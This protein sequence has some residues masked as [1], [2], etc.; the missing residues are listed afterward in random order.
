MVK[1]KDRNIC[2]EVT[3]RLTGSV[4]YFNTELRAYKNCQ[5]GKIISVGEN[6]TGFVVGQSVIFPSSYAL[7][8]AQLPQTIILAQ[9]DILGIM[10]EK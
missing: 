9:K 8:W 1:T 2:I 3:Q 6:V 10:E 4:N 5:C 7:D